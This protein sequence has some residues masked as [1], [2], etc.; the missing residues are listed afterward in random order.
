MPD[1]YDPANKYQVRIQLHGGVGGRRDNQP[2]GTGL[3]RR[4]GRRR[5]DLRDSV[6]VVRD[7][8]GG[9]T[10]KSTTS[11]AIV[12]AVKR[13]YNVDE[14][15]VVV[16]GVSDGGTGAY[17]VAM[18]DTTPYASFLPLNGYWMVLASRDIDDGEIF[19][20]NLRNKPLFVVNGGRDPLYPTRIVDPYV[21]H[22]KKGGVSARLSSAAR[23]RTQHAVVAGR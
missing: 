12:D 17:Y 1:A 13:R 2:V 7:R 10:I 22:Y 3:D 9:A 5:A 16:S 15:R 8:P 18:R 19:A 21:E 6:R 11:H 4:A 20:N 23:G 14:N